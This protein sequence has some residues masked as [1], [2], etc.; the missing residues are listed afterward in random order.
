MWAASWS[1]VRRVGSMELHRTDD[2]A[3]WAN[4][5]VMAHTDAARKVSIINFSIRPSIVSAYLY[6][7]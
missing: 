3:L 1:C 4:Q 7:L 6:V 2:R 5:A